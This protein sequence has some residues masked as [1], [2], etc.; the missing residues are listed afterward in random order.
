ML[1][2]SF[3][4]HAG[5]NG[6]GTTTPTFSRGQNIYQFLDQNPNLQRNWIT[7]ADRQKA[8]I[9]KQVASC[10]TTTGCNVPTS[11]DRLTGLGHNHKT[12]KKIRGKK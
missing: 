10:Q 4:A 5:Q 2:S 9:A 11:M 8:F 7:S 6:K 1:V 3:S 12:A